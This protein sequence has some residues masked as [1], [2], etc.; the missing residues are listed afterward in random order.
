MKKLES[1]WVTTDLLSDLANTLAEF[2][3]EEG[4]VEMAMVVPAPFTSGDVSMVVAQIPVGV[5]SEGHAKKCSAEFSPEAL[6]QYTALE[7]FL[8]QTVILKEVTGALLQDK[9]A[10]VDKAVKAKGDVAAQC[11]ADA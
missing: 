11:V 9:Q 1:V 7:H 3:N 8:V 5:S 4:Y 10:V 2:C 6:T